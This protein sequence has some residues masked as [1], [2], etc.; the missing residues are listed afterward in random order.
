MKNTNDN[1]KIKQA[2]EAVTP[3][4]LDAVLSDLNEQKGTGFMMTQNKK[5]NWVRRVSGIAAAFVLLAGTAVSVNAYRVSNT[6]SSTVALDVN[7]SVE[8]KVNAKEKVLSVDALN[9]DGKTIIGDMDFKGS[10]KIG[11]ASCR[12]RV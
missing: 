6:V 12:E 2:F 5:N 3:D 10:D 7:P 1:K 8:I 9:E 4:V 11:R